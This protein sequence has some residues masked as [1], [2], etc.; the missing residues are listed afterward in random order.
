M[1]GHLRKVL[2]EDRTGSGVVGHS[3]RG[4]LGPEAHHDEVRREVRSTPLGHRQHLDLHVL[5]LRHGGRAASGGLRYHGLGRPAA[6]VDR[7][8]GRSG[9]GPAGVKPRA[10]SSRCPGKPGRPRTAPASEKKRKGPAPVLQCTAVTDV[11]FHEALLALATMQGG[12]GHPPDVLA[13]DEFLRCELGEH[14]P[15]RHPVRVLRPSPPPALLGR[16]RP[17]RR[18][19]RRARS[20]G[21]PAAHRRG[22]LRRAEEPDRGRG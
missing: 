8:R 22:P 21:G 12:P 2:D 6:G 13:E 15:H 10:D 11:P 18:P 17:A 20:R 4:G 19:R 5:A 16:D 9:V 7:H 3:F 14:H 1:C